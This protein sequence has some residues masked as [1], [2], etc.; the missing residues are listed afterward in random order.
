MRRR[1]FIILALGLSACGSDKLNAAFAGLWKGPA[2]LTWGSYLPITDDSV[3]VT[4]TLPS[5]TTA[6]LAPVCPDSKGSLTGSGSGDSVSWSGNLVCDPASAGGLCASV[7]VTLTSG[8]ATL[9]SDAKTL[10]ATASGTATGCS[11][12]QPF[13]WTFVGTK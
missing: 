3:Q 11:Q 5:D 9:S 10:T 6:T 8:K 7:V 4:V 2:T 13:S 1:L 12:T